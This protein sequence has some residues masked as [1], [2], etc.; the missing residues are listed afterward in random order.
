VKSLSAILICLFLSSCHGQPALNELPA[1]SVILAF[2]DSLTYGYGAT[3]D[4]SYPSD[5]QKMTGMKVINSGV[6]GEETQQSL[7]RIRQELAHYHP[8]LVIV[9]LGGNDFLRGR[10][11]VKVKENLR[12]I[13]TQIQ[14]TGAQVILI[15]VPIP[16]LALKVPSLYT[17]LGDELNIPVETEM[18]PKLL[19]T[20][21]YKSDYIHFNTQGYRVFAEDIAAFLKKGGAIP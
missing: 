9:C 2:G 7:G 20:P 4:T 8:Q 1:N 10:S 3:H 17:E 11:L 21:E 12:Q 14:D 15:G 18:I 13:I 5:L 6:S 16:G 19:Q